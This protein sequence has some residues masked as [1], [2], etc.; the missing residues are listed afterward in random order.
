MSKAKGEQFVALD[1]T[2][3]RRAEATEAGMGTRGLGADDR[4]P[5]EG[6]G[7]GTD[8]CLTVAQTSMGNMRLG[9]LKFRLTTEPHSARVGRRSY[10][11]GIG[12][13]LRSAGGMSIGLWSNFANDRATNTLAK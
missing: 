13:R 12:C 7:S 2:A 6:S 4:R 3:R 1:M 8:R 10:W 11:Y 5:Y 9:Y